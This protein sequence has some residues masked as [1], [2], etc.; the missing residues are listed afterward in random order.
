M[1]ARLFFPQRRALGLAVDE[2]LSPALLE[3]VTYLGAKLPS[4][5]DAHEAL[6]VLLRSEIGLKRVE[7]ITER[8]GSERVAERESRIA[9][10]SDLPL[11]RRD[12]APA[13]VKPPGVAAV[14]ADGGR[15]QTCEREEEATSHWHEYKAGVLQ[16]LS[17]E[18]HTS[19]PCPQIP[20]VY[21]QRDRI[22]RLT[23]EI[24]QVAAVAEPSRSRSP[25]ESRP[26]IEQPL[27]TPQEIIPCGYE[28]PEVVDR[29]VVAS[30]RDS[31]AF[32]KHLAAQAWSLGLFAA[33]RKAWISDGQ[34][35][36]WTEYEKYFKPFGFV[37]ILDFIHALTHVYAAAMAGRPLAVGWEVYV[38]WITWI[39]HG[40]VLPVIAEL[41][42]RQQELGPPGNDDGETSPRRLIAHT[43]TYLQNQKERMNYPAYRRQGLP[44][45]SAHMESTVKQLNRRIKGSEKYWSERGSEAVLQLVADQLS[46]SRP[47]HAFWS[48]RPQRQTGYRTYA[49]SAA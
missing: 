29:D 2:E 47:L 48:E 31:R 37:P 17:S 20:E 4:F 43:L 49:R 9:D 40:N 42:A 25:E 32:G 45:T 39:W 1:P 46:T 44:I 19:D 22:D 3:K 5:R 26:E 30:R 28:P 27:I 36:L 33:L 16:I 11:I 34:N 41:A 7:R 38:R 10:W 12:Q 13:G 14:L 24:S 18:V 35:W 15:F 8:I 23:R 21:L 6:D